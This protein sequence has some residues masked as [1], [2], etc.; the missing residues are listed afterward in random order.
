ML[1]TLTTIN[2]TICG[3]YLQ[4]VQRKE[5]LETLKTNGAKEIAQS[6]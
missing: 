3:E 6:Q 4:L 2:V 1:E 5:P